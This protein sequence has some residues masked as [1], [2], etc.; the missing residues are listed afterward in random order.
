MLNINKD[1]LIDNKIFKNS[2]KFECDKFYD[3]NISLEEIYENEITKTNYLKN[4]YKEFYGTFIFIGESKDQF[5]DNTKLPG[6]FLD[7]ILQ[8]VFSFSKLPFKYMKN[9]YVISVS[10]LHI[11]DGK[12]S[13]IFKPE[14]LYMFSKR[15]ILSGN[16]IEGVREITIKSYDQCL[17]ALK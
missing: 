6:F 5:F 13:D 8:E 16:L 10:Y 2:W 15:K 11:Q 4:L 17:E 1:Y 9:N 7:K 14:L 12:V 3:T